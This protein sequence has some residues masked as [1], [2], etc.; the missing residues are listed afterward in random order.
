M[1]PWI[2]HWLEL[3]IYHAWIF[4]HWFSAAEPKAVIQ[5]NESS[6]TTENKNKFDAGI[7][8]LIKDF[9]WNTQPVSANAL[10][11]VKNEVMNLFDEVQIPLA[12]FV[13]L[14]LYILNPHTWQNQFISL[15]VHQQQ[16]TLPAPHQPPPMP[17]TMNHFSR[18]QTAYQSSNGNQL[19]SQ[20]W[21]RIGTQVH[22]T[23]Q[24]R[25]SNPTSFFL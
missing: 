14:L 9:Q 15:S 6:A 12:L 16:Q 24:V 3:L 21:G 19:F 5:Q 1:T 22:G 20:S 17:A 13:Y 10:N 23:K 25:P 8:E 4:R 18:L 2:R 7:E 11:N